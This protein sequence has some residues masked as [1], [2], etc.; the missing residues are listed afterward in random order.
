MQVVNII[1]VCLRREVPHRLAEA[2]QTKVESARAGRY[3]ISVGG[4]GLV[5]GGLDVPR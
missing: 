4:G 2:E 1:W 5:R 3:R